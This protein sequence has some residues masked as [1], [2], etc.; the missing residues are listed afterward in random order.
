M[1]PL[2][3]KVSLEFSGTRTLQF[4]TTQ[5]VRCRLRPIGCIN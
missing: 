1:M 2:G 3:I 4:E 5:S